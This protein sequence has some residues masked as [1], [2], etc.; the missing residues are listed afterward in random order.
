MFMIEEANKPIELLKNF[1]KLNSANSSHELKK[2]IC[3]VE[4]AS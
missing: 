2:L 4:M 1:Y 3:M